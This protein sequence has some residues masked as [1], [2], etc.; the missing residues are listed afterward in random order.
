VQYT[1]RWNFLRFLVPGLFAVLPLVTQ[2]GA[3]GAFLVKGGAMSLADD[4][5]TVDFAQLRLDGNSSRAFAINIEARM[6]NGV[7]LGAEY[8]S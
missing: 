7:A 4:S 5:Q 2:A 6:R 3:G 1:H 8:L